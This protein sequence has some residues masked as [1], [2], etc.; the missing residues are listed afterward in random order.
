MTVSGRN[1]QRL[2]LPV[3]LGTVV[4]YQILQRLDRILD[5]LLR[6]LPLHAVALLPPDEDGA[7]EGEYK[8]S[9]GVAGFRQQSSPDL[10][11]D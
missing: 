11:A 2:P 6:S 7:D 8:P 5:V 9:V 10:K 4:L 3:I 1:R